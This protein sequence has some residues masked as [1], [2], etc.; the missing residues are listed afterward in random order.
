MKQVNFQ[1]LILFSKFILQRQHIGFHLIV[2]GRIEFQIR[3][4]Y[5][6]L[7]MYLSAIS[8]S[9]QCSTTAVKRLRCVLSCLCYGAYK[10]YIA[11]NRKKV[12]GKMAAAGFHF[13]CLSGPLQYNCK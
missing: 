12:A 11:G 6:Q 13:H 1:R 4:H 7:P 2:L 8:S 10:R 3:K 9:G 5:L